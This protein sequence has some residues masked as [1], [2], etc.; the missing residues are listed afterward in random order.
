MKLDGRKARFSW[1]FVPNRCKSL[2]RVF[3][4]LRLSKVYDILGNQRILVTR[5]LQCPSRTHFLLHYLA[6][7][8][9][10]QRF[11]SHHDN[12]FL[13][14]TDSLLRLLQGTIKNILKALIPFHILR[15]PVRRG[16]KYA[17]HRHE[18]TVGLIFSER[19]MRQEAMGVDELETATGKVVGEFGNPA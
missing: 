13:A 15:S 14:D 9:F 18:I 7:L 17:F 8:H 16:L 11:P 12:N 5:T 1:K 10:L 4:P 6:V 3:D 2:T 19:A